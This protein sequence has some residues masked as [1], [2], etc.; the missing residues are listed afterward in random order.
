MKPRCTGCKWHTPI[1]FGG[2]GIICREIGDKCPEW[3]VKFE[4]QY[5]DNPRKSI[6]TDEQ[7]LESLRL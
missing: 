7:L 6:K 1:I 2:Q 4:L 5:G 3:V